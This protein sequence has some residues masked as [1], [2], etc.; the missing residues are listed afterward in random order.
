MS[1]ESDN[2]DRNVGINAEIVVSGKDEIEKLQ[3]QLEEEKIAKED[4][5]N[6]LEMIAEAEFAKAKAKLGAPD[7]I[8]TPEQLEKYKQEQESKKSDSKG[9]MGKAPL[10]NE[11]SSQISHVK[12]Y[13]SFNEMMEDLQ[14]R[15][16]SDNKEVAQEAQNIQKQLFEKM[17]KEQKSH[18]FEF[19][20][21][22]NKI[23]EEKKEK[24]KGVMNWDSP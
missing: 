23:I 2:K 14:K 17:I 12:E 24:K 18:N 16:N 1:E 15:M 21:D 13:G 20:V 11:P 10:Y 7:Y 4:A 3:Q 6:K 9:A 22:L 19:E 8:E 5:L